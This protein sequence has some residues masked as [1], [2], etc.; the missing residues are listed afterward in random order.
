MAHTLRSF[1]SA[2]FPD[3]TTPLY[4]MMLFLSEG[5]IYGIHLWGRRFL[6]FNLS[7]SFSVKF[8]NPRPWFSP[9]TFR[10]KIWSCMSGKVSNGRRWIAWCPSSSKS[11]TSRLLANLSI[12][13]QKDVQDV[14]Q[15]FDTSKIAQATFCAMLGNDVIELGILHG[16]WLER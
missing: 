4:L 11:L 8:D 5:L 16:L 3:W 9:T 13:H 2:I 15:E 1:T 10:W 7:S 14:A 6:I 12:F